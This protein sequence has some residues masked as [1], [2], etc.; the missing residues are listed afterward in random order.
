[1]GQVK[2][3]YQEQIEREQRQNEDLALFQ[4]MV[5]STRQNRRPLT[6]DE[7]NYLA[8]QAAKEDKRGNL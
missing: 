7:I 1:M 5:E 8:E 4:M 2:A 6:V 3:F